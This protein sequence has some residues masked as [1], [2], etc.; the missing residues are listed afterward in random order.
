MAK[1]QKEFAHL[2]EVNPDFAP[3]IPGVNAAFAKIWRY[4]DMTEFRENWTKTR[5]SYP[6]FVPSEG[7]QITR[8][9]IPARD[10]CEL[11]IRI[12]KPVATVKEK[13][14]L[15]FVLHGG[16]ILHLLLLEWIGLNHRR[17]CCR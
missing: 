12:W 8:R 1:D 14:P 16:G 6:E 7:F 3:L 15:L 5:S 11:E 13:L 10:G 2:S 9:M 4:G 17:I